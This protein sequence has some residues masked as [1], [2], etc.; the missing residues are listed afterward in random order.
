MPRAIVPGQLSDEKIQMDLQT[1]FNQYP[2][3]KF[4]FTLGAGSSLDANSNSIT[5]TLKKGGQ[6]A[7]KYDHLI[8]VTRSSVKNGMP[9][10]LGAST[11]TT[12]DSLHRLQDKIRKPQTVVV[13]GSGLRETE[14]ASELGFGYASQGQKEVIFIYNDELP[15]SSNVLESVREQAVAELTN[16]GVKV[17]PKTNVTDAT[18]E[19]AN[20]IIK[21]RGS[22]EKLSSVM[23][24]AYIPT[25]GLSLNLCTNQC[26]QRRR[27]PQ[28]D[29]N[30]TGGG[31]PKHLCYRRCRRPGTQ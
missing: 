16:L 30:A 7:V 20:K 29:D 11:D 1:Q 22:N 8:L 13:A 31:P 17:M 3:D 19:G 26:A 2:A 23:A 28:A 9:W 25:L 21:V 4:K 5:V 6:K 14:T 27:L 15:L 24:Q 10:N 18:T 12:L